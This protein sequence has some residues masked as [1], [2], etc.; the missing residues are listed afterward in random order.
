MSRER[1]H[2][3]DRRW[4]LL[5]QV[6]REPIVDAHRVALVE[7]RVHQE[8]PSNRL[9]PSR[10]VV[11]AQ[12]PVAVEVLGLLEIDVMF[13]GAVQAVDRCRGETQDRLLD[14]DGQDVA[15][16][17]LSGYAIILNRPAFWAIACKRPRGMVQPER[18]VAL[19]CTNSLCFCK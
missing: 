2:D 15:C 9:L 1:S 8:D 11:Y 17:D 16:F 4:P 13:L 5:N 3:A 14:R 10:A 7:S 18:T 6:G 19:C 12:H